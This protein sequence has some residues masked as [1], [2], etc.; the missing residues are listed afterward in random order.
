M[1]FFT[2]SAAVV[3]VLA[4]AAPQAD[5]AKVLKR[6]NGKVARAAVAA[7]AA[8]PIEIDEKS[9]AAELAAEEAAYGYDNYYYNAG[10][11]VGGS[12]IVAGGALL[13]LAGLALF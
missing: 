12:P 7:P 8:D 5:A 3:L 6:A 11:R 10:A 9:T 4:L 13:A 1:R 2:V